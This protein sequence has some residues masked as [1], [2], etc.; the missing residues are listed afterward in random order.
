MANIVTMIQDELSIYDLSIK[1][2]QE[3][4]QE[5][6]RDNLV[7]IR[8]CDNFPYNHELLSKKNS[9]YLETV[10]E[11]LIPYQYYF[12]DESIICPKYKTHKNTIHFT[13][14]GLIYKNS[15]GLSLSHLYV[16]IDPL[17]NHLN[18]KIVVLR[19]EDTSIEERFPISPEASI[20]MS[21]QTYEGLSE[22]ERSELDYY[23]NIILYNLDIYNNLVFDENKAYNEYIIEDY[24]VRNALNK[25]NLPSFRIGEHSYQDE[26]YD[27]VREVLR[28][29]EEIRQ[30]HDIPSSRNIMY[31]IHEATNR[32]NKE[33]INNSIYH[34]LLYL[35][36]HA[37]ISN[38]LKDKI[39]N[40]GE[41]IM[42]IENRDYVKELITTIG[43]EEYNRLT[44]E[45]NESIK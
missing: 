19:P 1:N 36:N 34:H 2:N 39:N 45:Y 38:E 29:L 21:T 43:K 7:L 37:N 28:I 14:N 13:V 4:H 5:V 18:D 42:D 22:S 35:N 8:A 44:N 6:T 30:E 15:L 27:D 31:E 25:L 10:N 3:R 12:Q 9:G 20:M 41:S 26:D 23:T 16:I 17:V 33:S 11:S 40:L 24:L 32:L